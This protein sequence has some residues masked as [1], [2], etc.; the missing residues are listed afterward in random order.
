[1]K[2]RYKEL[3]KVGFTTA[4]YVDGQAH[5]DVL[6]EPTAFCRK[7]LS[8][9]HILSRPSADGITLY[10]EANPLTDDATAFKPINQEEQ[11]LFRAVVQNPD[12]WY[13]ADVNGW[14]QDRVF[15]LKNTVYNTTGDISLLNGALNNSVL[16]RPLKF[17]HDVPLQA[18]QSVLEVLDAAGTLL[19]SVAIRARAD[20]EEADKPEGVPVDLT[21]AADGLYTL[22]HRKNSGDSDEVAYCTADY[23][24]G[25]FALVEITYR[26]DVAW[27]GVAPLQHY[28][29]QLAARPTEWVY[30]VY[31]RPK[32][33]ATLLASQLFIKHEP[34]GAE[35]V[36]TFTVVTADDAAGYVK[37]KSDNPL[38]FS[39][40][41]MRLRLVTP[42]LVTPTDVLANLPGPSART[43]VKVGSALATRIIVNI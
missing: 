43:I 6:L 42:D 35:P 2:L 22:R 9:F 29:V 37:F 15:F 34:V 32:P 11:F 13:Y 12:L 4:Y 14:K 27:T 31:L 19:K 38:L 28:R 3:F 24:P 25:T 8:R 10:Y 17:V 5:N 1:M 23:R 41:P 7:Q 33:M 36:Q 30:E 20:D 40:R 16:H 39:Q 21:T 18:E 26:G